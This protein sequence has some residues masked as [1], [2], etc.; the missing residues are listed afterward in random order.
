[1]NIDPKKYSI[2]ELHNREYIRLLIDY[3]ASNVNELLYKKY[4]K[5]VDVEKIRY[6]NTKIYRK[7]QLNKETNTNI[8]NYS[9]KLGYW[10]PVC[11]ART[12]NDPHITYSGYNDS[13]KV[14]DL[15]ANIDGFSP[16]LSEG[17]FYNQQ[18]VDLFNTLP[19]NDIIQMLQAY[20]SDKN[21]W[22]TNSNYDSFCHNHINDSTSLV[23]QYLVDFDKYFN[24]KPVS[25][26]QIQTKSYF[27]ISPDKIEVSFLRKCFFDKDL[28]EVVDECEIEVLV[29]DTCQK[30]HF[31]I[32]KRVFPNH[33]K[34]LGKRVGETFTL[35]NIPYT[36]KIIRIH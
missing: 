4:E 31:I 24:L 19:T 27:L 32:Y 6:T 21:S 34:I 36:Y 2:L 26:D 29:T 14:F 18:I 8:S 22:K 13:K 10:V 23:R 5:F 35:P 11:D 16:S 7:Q 15:N 12:N 3:L 17:D 1:M 30:S 25:R 33:E 9:A 20:I 28:P